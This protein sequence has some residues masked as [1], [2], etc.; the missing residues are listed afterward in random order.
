MTRRPSLEA[1]L[2]S[3]DASAAA[4]RMM[5]SC[6]MGQHLDAEAVELTRLAPECREY[7]SVAEVEERDDYMTP[8]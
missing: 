7:R 2:A 6:L 5:G 4:A 3:D 8:P 1:A